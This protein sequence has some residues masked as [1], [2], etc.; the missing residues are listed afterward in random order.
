M[1]PLQDANSFVSTPL[2]HKTPC[3]QHEHEA[4]SSQMSRRSCGDTVIRPQSHNIKPGRRR[5]G[6]HRCKPGSWTWIL[7]LLVLATV[8]GI[9]DA[10]NDRKRYEAEFE[11]SDLAHR[12]GIL[13]DTRP[14]PRVGKR[15]LRFFPRQDGS[16]FGSTTA[17]PV[18]TSGVAPASTA[19]S[20]AASVPS[21]SAEPSSVSSASSSSTPTASSPLMTASTV[22]TNQPLPRPFDTS[23][24]SN[25]TSSSCPAFFDSFLNNA[26]FSSCLPFSLLL[27]VCHL[28]SIGS[29]LS[30]TDICFVIELQF[31]F[32]GREIPDTTH[33]DPRCNMQS[34]LCHLFLLDVQLSGRTPRRRKLW[35]GLLRRKRSCGAGVQ[36]S[37]LLLHA[38]PSGLPQRQPWELLFCQ[39]HHKHILPIRPLSIFSATRLRPPGRIDSNVLILSATN[40]EHLRRR[41]EQPLS[42]RQLGLQQRGYSDRS[43][44]RPDVCEL[45]G[46]SYPG[47]AAV[48]QR[49]HPLGPRLGDDS[50]LGGCDWLVGD[51][52][53]GK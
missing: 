46:Q 40:D 50:A 6:L 35:T 45:D 22:P 52:G 5:L 39:R 9:S 17:T 20:S 38:L 44:L 24:G 12:G 37:R 43:G 27:Q 31:I 41:G 19:S 34:R 16:L 23:L 4:E 15:E 10:E 1:S 26:T 33:T 51:L 32:S 18:S 25:F 42:A 11:L 7:T 29:L 28:P 14:V 21:T 13:I 49:C 53:L 48:Q 2:L 30:T 47:H 3:L 36:R 8:C